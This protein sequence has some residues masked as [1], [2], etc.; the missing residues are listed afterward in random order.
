MKASNCSSRMW[1]KKK[2]YSSLSVVSDRSRACSSLK[3][4]QF[5]NIIHR[6][7]LYDDGRGV[8]E[9]LNESD[10]VRTKELIV[11]DR[12]NTSAR[13]QRANTLLL[14]NPPILAF[15]PVDN[16]Q[17]WIKTYRTRFE[18]IVALPPN[19]HLLDLKTL[20]TGRV[21]LRLQHIFAVGEDADFSKPVSVDLDQLFKELD[22]I[23]ITE[24][25]LTGVQKKSGV[26]RLSWK[27]ATE[28]LPSVPS[29]PL[30]GHMVQ[31]W[32][33][34]DVTLQGA[35]QAYGDSNLP[36]PVQPLV[37]LSQADLSLPGVLLF[38]MVIMYSL[39]ILFV[40]VSCIVL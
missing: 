36:C 26:H 40:F 20:D 22:I 29:K 16:L 37:R 7:L 18:P 11:F 21:L 19:V 39:T 3:D 1:W 6:R 38:L 35:T 9:P 34:L 27:T 30:V 28:A 23:D 2:V 8:G 13:Q 4:G 24:M 14:N 17:N 25:N 31:L 33:S 12:T 10:I 32:I 5:E 15:A